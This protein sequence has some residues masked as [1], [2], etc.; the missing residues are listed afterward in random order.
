MANVDIDT[1]FSDKEY[2]DAMEQRFGLP[3][4]PH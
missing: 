3:S 2:W 4:D 1:Y